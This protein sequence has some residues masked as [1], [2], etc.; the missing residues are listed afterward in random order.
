[1]KTFVRLSG[2]LPLAVLLSFGLLIQSLVMSQH[3]RAASM[4]LGGSYHTIVICADGELRSI[5]VNDTGEPVKHNIDIPHCALCLAGEHFVFEHRTPQ[6]D[7]AFG[8]ADG[9]RFFNR[10]FFLVT[11]NEPDHPNCL[12]P[13]KV[14]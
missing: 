11:T 9:Q 12:D 7:P 3:A 1:M 4:D 10:D 5:T 6:P 2:L 14:A 13:P 8:Y